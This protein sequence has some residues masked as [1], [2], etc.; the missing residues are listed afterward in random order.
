MTP[1]IARLPLLLLALMLGVLTTHAAGADKLLFYDGFENGRIP[2]GQPGA[3]WKPVQI[4]SSQIVATPARAGNHAMQFT[5]DYADPWILPAS[6]LR[7]DAPATVNHFQM[8]QSYWYGFSI[9]VPEALTNEKSEIVN[10]FHAI[11]DTDLGESWGLNPPFFLALNGD[12][13]QVVI[14]ADASPVTRKGEYDVTRSWDLGPWQAGRWTDWVY[15]IKWS[16]QSDGIVRIWKDGELV[17]DYRG[18]NTFND[19]KGPFWKIGIYEW[20]WKFGPT[21]VTRRTLYYDEIRVGGAQ[22]TYADVAPGQGHPAPPPP[23]AEKTRVTEGL[24]ALYTFAEGGGQT[25]HDVSGVGSPLHLTIQDAAAVVWNADG[26]TL[27]SPTL[28]RTEQPAGKI[29]TACQASAAVTLEAWITPANVTQDGPARILTMSADPFRRNFMLGQGLWG[30]QAANR[31]D[32][33]LRTTATNGNGFPSLST[34]AGSAQTA[35]THLVYTR[36]AGGAAVLYLNGQPQQTALRGGSLANW[37]AYPL[38]LGNELS[39][40]RPWLGAYHL[41]AVYCRALSGEEVARNY[42]AGYRHP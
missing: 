33:R 31:F 1:R 8:G 14:R 32:A 39:G 26:L 24:Q 41:A 34:S 21:A 7:L 19:Q 6:E 27:K 36:S 17:L 13:W 23:P 4:D 2:Y 35:Q 37:E 5:L 38:I 3:V 9:Y 40:D 10:Q 30:S 20:A 16:Y 28:L 12:R 42:A 29:L 22:A 11:P 25:V 18:P 15:Q